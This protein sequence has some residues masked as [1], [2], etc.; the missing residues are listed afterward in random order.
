MDVFRVYDLCV[1]R[2]CVEQ[3][4]GTEVVGHSWDS[5]SNGV[6]LSDGGVGEQRAGGASLLQGVFDVG[7][8]RSIM[9]LPHSPPWRKIKES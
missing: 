8:C 2:A 9:A 5:A 6:Y 1:L 3:A 4:R 7:L